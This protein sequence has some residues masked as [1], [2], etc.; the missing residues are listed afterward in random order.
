MKLFLD[1][2]FITSLILEKDDLHKKSLL[3]KEKGILKNECY[4]SNL[5]INE[6]VTAIGNKTDEKIAKISYHFLKDNFIL[7]EDIN[8][9]KSN[10][11]TIKTYLK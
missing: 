7:I 4:I 2:S 1:N 10:D 5:I 11:K 3:L 9:S 8:T 6:V